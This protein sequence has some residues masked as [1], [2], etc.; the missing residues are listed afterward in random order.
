MPFPLSRELITSSWDAARLVPESRWARLLSR[1]CFG[2]WSSKA[3]E[4]SATVGGLSKTH[5]Q[6]Q[7]HCFREMM[8]PGR[9]FLSSGI[10]SGLR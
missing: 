10:L 6:I 1:L 3:D 9:G 2:E 5:Y 4:G 8:C 7:Y